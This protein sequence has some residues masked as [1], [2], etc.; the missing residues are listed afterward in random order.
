ME[1]LKQITVGLAEETLTWQ[2]AVGTTLLELLQANGVYPKA[3]CGGRG[4]CGKCQVQ[5]TNGSFSGVTPDAHGRIL[6]CRARVLTDAT[7]VIPS[8]ALAGVLPP[9]TVLDPS[10]GA[11]DAGSYVMAVD[12]GTTTI[13]ASLLQEASGARVATCALENPQAVWGADVISRILAAE[14]GH[15]PAMQRAVLRT[16]AGMAH[17]FERLVGKGRIRR[18]AVAANTTMQHL[19][20]GVNPASIGQAPYTPVFVDARELG[21]CLEGLPHLSVTLLPS[22]SSFIGA[23]ILVGLLSVGY[24]QDD[25]NRLFVDLGTNAEVVLQVGGRLFATSAAAG[26]ALEGANI[27]C[28]M[29]GTLG[30]VSH[31]RPAGDK[32]LL[33]TIGEAPPAGIC[34]SGLMDLMA[35]LLEAGVVDEGGAFDEADT[36]LRSHLRG[37]RF[38]FEEELSLSQRDVRAFQTAKAAI[39]GVVETLLHVAGS[40][41]E[42]IGQVH[43]AGGLGYH[44]SPESL[45]RCGLFPPAFAGRITAVGNTSLAGAELCLRSDRQ[46]ELARLREACTVVD[47]NCDSYFAEAFV[48]AMAFEAGAGMP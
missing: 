33:S 36:L 16:L 32:L 15:L 43:V 17:A 8:G 48:D 1:E 39:R 29:G 6:S 38:F 23:D 21:A 4:T 41:A 30:A 14:R 5:L 19:A 26:P 37:D 3:P 46:A 25:T 24:L 11:T 34:G 31:V 18:A 7:I 47:L 27:S 2:A 13:A 42:E 40:R 35:V 20:A 28:G 12:L 45:L 44:V 9:V 10:V 22:V